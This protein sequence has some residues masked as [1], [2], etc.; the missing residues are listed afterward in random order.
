MKGKIAALGVVVPALLALSVSPA[1]SAGVTAAAGGGATA[2]GGG[3]QFVKLARDVGCWFRADEPD[4]LTVGS[5]TLWGS[6]TITRCTP[7]PPDKCHVITDI[8]NPVYTINRNDDKWKG[9]GKKTVKVAYTCKDLVSK[10]QYVTVGHL[11][12]VYKGHTQ[13]H[14]FKS[15]TVTQYCGDRKSVV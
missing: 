10:H 9:C 11:A 12:M 3:E 4:R 14:V 7:R 8:A 13:S 6:V 1:S 15:K 2:K 5:H